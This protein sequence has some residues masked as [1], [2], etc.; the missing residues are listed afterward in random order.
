VLSI[1]LHIKL[2]VCNPT[3]KSQANAFSPNW[4]TTIFQ[5]A[6]EMANNDMLKK[7]LNSIFTTLPAEKAAWEAR[8]ES[9]REGFMKELEGEKTAPN[10]DAAEGKKE[11]TTAKGSSDED[12]VTV[13]KGGDALSANA[14]GKNKKKKNKK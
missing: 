7:R 13:E 9:M 14:G 8:R 10:T 6:N 1:G 5:S 2:Q 12:A 11:S 3:K 4:G